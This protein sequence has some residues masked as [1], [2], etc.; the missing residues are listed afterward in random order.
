MTLRTIRTVALAL[1]TFVP[2]TLASH[3]AV[4]EQYWYYCHTAG[5]YYPY[6]NNCPVPWRA[7]PANTAPTTKSLPERGASSAPTPP[8]PDNTTSPTP[9]SDA[10]PARDIEAAQTS[11]NEKQSGASSIITP[12]Q[13][14]D[15]AG[16]ALLI[17]VLGV[18]LTMFVVW[19]SARRR[20]YRYLMEKYRDAFVV[21]AIL[22]H[23]I[24]QGMSREQLLDSRGE[25]VEIGHEI[26]KQTTRETFKI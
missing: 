21:D 3:L 14:H 22:R 25:L 11:L 1:L 16:Y 20:R 18:A 8:T 6:V 13:K 9:R 12:N 5:A 2:S 26:Y 4:A 10:V 23:R 7:V 24:W 19:Y 17:A 15:G